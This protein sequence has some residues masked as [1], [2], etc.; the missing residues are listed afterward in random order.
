MPRPPEAGGLKGLEQEVESYRTQFNLIT[1]ALNVKKVGIGRQ[2]GGRAGGGG[3]QPTCSAA[4]E[5][6]CARRAALQLLNAA[7]SP[8]PRLSKQVERDSAREATR[9]ARDAFNQCRAAHDE[10]AAPVREL[11]KERQEASSSANK[12]KDSFG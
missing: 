3:S 8:L 11:Q 1:E 7:P 5:Y 10:R 12:L 2:A 9:A 4:A 6:Y